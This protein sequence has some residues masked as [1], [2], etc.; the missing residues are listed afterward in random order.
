[1]FDDVAI[2]RIALAASSRVSPALGVDPR[3]ELVDLFVGLERVGS[4]SL[5][6][7]L[8]ERDGGAIEIPFDREFDRAVIV[9][10]LGRLKTDAFG[11]GNAS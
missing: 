2:Q 10:R 5:R 11:H 9:G 6:T 1:L 7:E 3:D 8:L 4:Q